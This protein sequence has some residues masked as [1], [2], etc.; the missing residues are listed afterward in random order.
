MTGK[1]FEFLTKT[2]RGSPNEKGWK[3]TKNAT[4][5]HEGEYVFLK[6]KR[7]GFWLKLIGGTLRKRLEN[8]EKRNLYL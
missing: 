8:H 3:T 6:R 4:C 7:K 5:V 2:D 1:K